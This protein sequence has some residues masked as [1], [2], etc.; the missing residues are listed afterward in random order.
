VS[1]EAHVLAEHMVVEFH[2]ELCISFVLYNTWRICAE[3]VASVPVWD[4]RRVV[5]RSVCTRRSKFTSGSRKMETQNVKEEMTRVGDVGVLS[6][7]SLKLEKIKTK[8]VDE[9]KQEEDDNILSDE[10]I[11]WKLHQEL[12]AGS[13]VLRTRSQRGVQPR[14][15]L[16]ESSFGVSGAME[17]QRSTNSNEH[18]IVEQKKRGKRSRG[19]SV[20]KK[21]SMRKSPRT[22]SKASEASHAKKSFPVEIDAQHGRSNDKV[23]SRK[24]KPRVAPSDESKYLNGSEPSEK[25]AL[26][27]K[28][29]KRAPP[30]IPKLPMVR[31]G[32]HWYR[33]R[34][35]KENKDT[36]LVEFAGYEHSLPSICLP[37]YCDR[38]WLG[39]YKGRDWRYHGEGAW[40]PKNG[41]ENR[42]ISA[43]KYD[44]T[45]TSTGSL[46]VREDEALRAL[47][48][49]DGKHHKKSMMSSLAV[50]TPNL[51]LDGASVSEENGSSGLKKRLADRTGEPYPQRDDG[52]GNAKKM[53][54]GR[55]GRP[56]KT[57]ARHSGDDMGNDASRSLD[58]ESDSLN[59]SDEKEDVVVRPSRPKRNTKRAAIF[60]SADFAIDTEA[61]LLDSD[62]QFGW[63]KGNSS[64]E[65]GVGNYIDGLE[66]LD[67]Q[68]ALAALA[69]MPASP[70]SLPEIAQA[71]AMI[72]SS[73]EAL[74]ELYT[75]GKHTTQQQAKRHSNA[76]KRHWRRAYKSEPNLHHSCTMES[77][78]VAERM[79][80]GVLHAISSRLG[81]SSNIHR[82]LSLPSGKTVEL[83]EKGQINGANGWS[84]H[85]WSSGVTPADGEPAIIQVPL[86]LIRNALGGSGKSKPPPQF[87]LFC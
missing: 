24:G 42:I 87:P 37:K 25:T 75:N 3:P 65:E 16:A 29:D 60:N 67:E 6:A 76:S 53:R 26:G 2:F 27:K 71:E 10:E 40:V 32:E 13:P 5:G 83:G 62:G 8:M 61:D 4:S 38:V 56:R 55:K 36:I 86:S 21:D 23:R 28:G 17:R 82:S 19:P 70:A 12:N 44:V 80:G 31:Q 49:T 7:D 63:R 30:K 64:A 45:P 77:I 69:G 79:F 15:N 74:L 22:S 39:S 34:V 35:L 54:G 73:R 66:S 68:E 51:Q 58:G 33:A 9:L 52:H 47:Q 46:P 57:K 78:L 72:E 1:L 50:E 11:A 14:T 18:G 43:E 59:L 85:I 84:P 81:Q 20:E 48:K 41:I